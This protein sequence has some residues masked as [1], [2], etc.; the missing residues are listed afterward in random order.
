MVGAQGMHRLEMARARTRDQA[1]EDGH[2]VDGVDADV[3]HLHAADVGSHRVFRRV[4]HTG[5]QRQ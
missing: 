2:L 1:D 3:A 4:L 5:T